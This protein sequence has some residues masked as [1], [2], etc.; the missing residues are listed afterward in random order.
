MATSAPR[1]LRAAADRRPPV[2][3]DHPGAGGGHRLEEVVAT[4]AEVD[5]G[6]V[7]VALGQLGEHAPRVG[8]DEVLVVGGRERAGPGVE[9]LERRGPGGE[10]DVDEL[11]G[12]RRQGVHQLVP[13]AWIGVQ[14]R[15]GVLVGAARTALD[16]VAGDGERSTGECQHRRRRRRARRPPG[17]TVSAT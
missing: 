9:Q 16:E 14:Q 2:E 8:Q 7:R 3:S 17:P 6:H 1:R 12:H 15:L 13:H 5:A 11:H 10:L 4:D